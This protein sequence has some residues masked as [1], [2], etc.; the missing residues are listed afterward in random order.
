MQVLK[1]IFKKSFQNFALGGQISLGEGASS[2]GALRPGSQDTYL[3]QTFSNYWGGRDN[4][5]K[6]C[7]KLIPTVILNEWVFTCDI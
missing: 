7:L 6:K 1:Y 5:G 4:M 2:P 3:T